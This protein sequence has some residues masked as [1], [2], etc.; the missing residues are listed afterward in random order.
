MLIP[1]KRA[2]MLDPI[3]LDG[4]MH[5][6]LMTEKEGR[7]WVTMYWCGAD[8]GLRVEHPKDGVCYVPAARVSTWYPTSDEYPVTVVQ[9]LQG[10]LRSMQTIWEYFTAEKR[11][12][13]RP[14]K[15]AAP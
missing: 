3:R 6:S 15:D 1:A 4:D 7:P 10:I 8:L 14:R 2:V 11:G 12:P 5:A 13:G 9:I